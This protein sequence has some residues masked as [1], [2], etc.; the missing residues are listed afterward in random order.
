MTA[1]RVV[2]VDTTRGKIYTSNVVSC[3]AGSTPSVLKMA[4][5]KSP[6]KIFP[7]QACVTEPIKPILD[8]IIVSGG[9]QAY[10]SQSSRGELVMGASLDPAI[11]HSTRSSF[12]FLEEMADTL[13]DLFPFVGDLKVVRQWA[14]MADITPDYAPIMGLTAIEG[15]FVSGGWGTYG[16]KATPVSGKT[17]A[18]TIANRRPH[19]LIEGFSLDRFSTLSL[20]GE[21]GAAAVGH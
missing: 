6:I 19:S 15:F 10:V 14:G 18:F 8:R 16:F 12:G 9:L 4:G 17:M 21:K 3:V 7:L 20:M 1:G 13:Q 2:S 5:L 11:H